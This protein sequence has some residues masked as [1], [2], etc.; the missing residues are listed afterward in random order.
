[1]PKIFGIEHIIYFTIVVTIM[2]I[3]II[4]IKKYLKDNAEKQSLLIKLIAFLLLIAIIYNRVSIA[5]GH[6]D[7]R[8]LLPDS[9]CGTSSLVLALS[10]IYFKKNNDILHCVAYLGLVGGTITL[11]YPDFIGQA[12]SIFH[13]MTI[14]GLLH[15][16]IMVFLV[17]VMLITGYLQPSLK[18]WKILPI[19]LSFY[20]IYGL[21]LIT[22][23]GLDDA[24]YIFNPALSGTIF[25]WFGLG[26]IF[27]PIHL[28]FL[29]VWDK[30]CKRQ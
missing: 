5:V 16:T 1:M 22:V 28:L 27:I 8:T 3:S 14:S 25:N 2:I 9:F 30:I 10:T 13:S 6:Q 29:F 15:H 18:K 7:Y 17:I 19:G 4:F 20:M 11:I 12:D 23:I 24:M 26:L 21:I